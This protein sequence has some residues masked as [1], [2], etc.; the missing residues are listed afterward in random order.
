METFEKS[1]S[2]YCYGSKFYNNMPLS[3]YDMRLIE[4]W[5]FTAKIQ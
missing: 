4:I 2:V 1:S 3:F 5:C